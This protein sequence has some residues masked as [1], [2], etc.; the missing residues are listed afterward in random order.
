M[1]A[2]SGDVLA[3]AICGEPSTIDLAPLSFARFGRH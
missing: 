1:S 2:T 3:R